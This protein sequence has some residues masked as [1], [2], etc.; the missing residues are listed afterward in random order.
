MAKTR[1]A[2]RG[3]YL[4]RAQADGTT[5]VDRTEEFSREQLGKMCEMLFTGNIDGESFGSARKNVEDWS[6][7]LM[8]YYVLGRISE[9]AFIRYRSFY[10]DTNYGV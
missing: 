7:L 6:L 5:L 3:L 1:G 8:D 2:V 10:F 9:V 4:K